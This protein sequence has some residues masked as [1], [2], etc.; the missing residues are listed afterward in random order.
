MGEAV[1]AGVG[2]SD[3]PESASRAGD[4]QAESE[5]AGRVLALHGDRA[6][7]VEDL[8]LLRDLG[9]MRDEVLERPGWLRRL[10]DDAGLLHAGELLPLFLRFDDGGLGR[11]A[12]EADDFRVLGRAEDDHAVALVGELL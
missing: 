5:L 3:P 7:S 4:P 8:G 6:D 2:M 1:T 12:E 10:R 9:D 11:E